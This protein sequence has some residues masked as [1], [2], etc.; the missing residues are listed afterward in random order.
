MESRLRMIGRG[1][2]LI[3]C[4]FLFNN[5]KEKGGVMREKFSDWMIAAA[6]WIVVILLGMLLFVNLGC[7]GTYEVN[8]KYEYKNN[9]K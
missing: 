2:Y 4:G 9:L 8:K 3:L 7:K 5:K 6:L 1:E